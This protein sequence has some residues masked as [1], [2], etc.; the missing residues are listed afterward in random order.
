MSSDEFVIRSMVKVD[1]PEVFSI[2]KKCYSEPW[3]E[4]V[5]LQGLT[6]EEYKSFVCELNEKIIGYVIFW[7]GVREVH[8]LNIAIEPELRRRGF[9]KRLLDFIINFSPIKDYPTII[10]EVRT[11][12]KPAISLYE[13]N[14]FGRISIREKYYSNGDDA[15]VMA[16]YR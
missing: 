14:G 10:L 12:N 2:E 3:S 6:R 7:R 8:L 15:L 1:L 5:F 9:G 4:D 13:S 11:N 16:L